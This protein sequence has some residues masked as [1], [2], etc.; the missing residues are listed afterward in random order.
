MSSMRICWGCWDWRCWSGDKASEALGL[1]AVLLMEI[2][3]SELRIVISAVSVA[4]EAG[5]LEGVLVGWMT[6]GS[7]YEDM[8][9]VSGVWGRAK[10]G[11]KE[12][13][14]V[15]CCRLTDGL[16]PLLCLRGG[17]FGDRL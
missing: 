14:V 13:Q 5:V 16:P 17:L 6:A 15:E 1:D 3:S 4:A 7:W 11:L 10:Q 12:L 9:L 8:V 2:W